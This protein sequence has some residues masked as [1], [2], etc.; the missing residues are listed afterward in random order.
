MTRGKLVAIL[1]VVSLDILRLMKNIFNIE[2][3]SKNTCIIYP[4]SV[5]IRGRLFCSTANHAVDGR[6]NI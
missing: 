4:D 3:F 2:L 5:F 1:D 6:I